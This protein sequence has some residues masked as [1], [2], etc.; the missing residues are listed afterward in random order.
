MRN[1]ALY[2]LITLAVISCTPDS[3][4]DTPTNT[5]D[6]EKIYATLEAEEGRVQLSKSLK[7]VWTEG[8]IM[9]VVGPNTR[10]KYKFDG[11]TGDI[12]G[13][14]SLTDT[15]TPYNATLDHYYAVA[16]FQRAAM[17]TTGRIRYYSSDAGTSVQKY[18]PDC[19]SEVN[20]NLVLAI[21]ED[22][23]NFR[24]KPVLSYLQLPITGEKVVKSINL[25]NNSGAEIS[26]RYYIYLDD[27]TTVCFLADSNPLST[28]FLDCGDGVQLSSTP[29]NF[30]F[31]IRPMELSE[32]I[33]VEITFTDGSTSIQT[34][35]E[36]I[37]VP[38]N[39]ILPVNISSTSSDAYQR[40]EITHENST[41]TIPTVSGKTT[42]F[43]YIELGDGSTVSLL[44][45]LTSY[46][47]TDG[48]T[49]HT[50]TIKARHAEKFEIKGC[51]GISEIDVSNF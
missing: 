42:M 41:F 37:T 33:T 44:D 28:I 2:F 27:P 30:Y 4:Q 32:G 18:N 19:A 48:K 38:Y 31:A 29:T 6:V 3:T 24:C 13:T 5:D 51:E 21:S 20:N 50:V 43:G 17:M 12:S 10:K 46:D 15:Y 22:G 14:F 49:S 47:Y 11:K 23:K 9:Y 35:V 8:D 34:T 16:S 45:Q 25:I 1:L 39:T 7:M 40:I 36:S 26:G